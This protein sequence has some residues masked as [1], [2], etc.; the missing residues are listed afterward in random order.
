[1]LKLNA[2]NA[3]RIAEHSILV[4]IK[5]M[6]EQGKFSLTIE[7]SPFTET[8]YDTT[9]T[10]KLEANGYRVEYQKNQDLYIISW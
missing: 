4:S 6:A 1:M 3:H 7:C 5:K 2:K 8:S 10:K 9:I